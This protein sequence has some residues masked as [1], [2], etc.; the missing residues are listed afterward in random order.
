ML[1]DVYGSWSSSLII[2]NIFNITQKND[3]IR[4]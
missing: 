2:N 1:L 3:G 4:Y